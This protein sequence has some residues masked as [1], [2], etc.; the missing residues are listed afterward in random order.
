MKLGEA[1]CSQIQ[2][3]VG[4]KTNALLSQKMKED[5][6]QGMMRFRQCVCVCVQIYIDLID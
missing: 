1:P 6:G 2:S 4:A 5:G 3:K